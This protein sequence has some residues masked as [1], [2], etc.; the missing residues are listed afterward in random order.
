M[1][2]FLSPLSPI[3]YERVF[4]RLVLLQFAVVVF[5]NGSI[6]F[7]PSLFL[8]VGVV[9]VDPG[10]SFD[11]MFDDASEEWPVM[12]LARRPIKVRIYSIEACAERWT[13]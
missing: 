4:E 7:P 9:D 3:A 1:L 11:D 10:V 2:F 5:S 13:L 6:L 12:M 8:P